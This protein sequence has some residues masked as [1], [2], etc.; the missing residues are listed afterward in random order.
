MAFV[1]AEGVMGYV[2]YNANPHTIAINYTY[3][4]PVNGYQSG[5]MVVPIGL[6]GALTTAAIRLAMLNKINADQGTSYIA[7]ELQMNYTLV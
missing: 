4:E 7:T 2:D 6:T 1:M 5:N 3:F